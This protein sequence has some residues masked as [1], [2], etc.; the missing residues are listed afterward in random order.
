[1]R[2]LIVTRGIPGSG[3]STALRNMGLADFTLSPDAFNVILSGPVLMSDGTIQIDHS[4]IK[5]SWQAT[6][7]FLSA[8]MSK[9]ETVVVDATH[10]GDSDFAQYLELAQKHRYQV[11]CLDFSGTPLEKALHQNQLREEWRRVPEHVIHKMHERLQKNMVLPAW[12]RRIEVNTGTGSHIKE[13]DAFLS[14]ATDF[15]DRSR[16]VHVGDIH[17][18]VSAAK[19]LVSSLGGIRKDDQW[20]FVGDFVDRGIQNA[21]V[22]R[23][24]LSDVMPHENVTLLWGNH[25]DHI[26]REAVGLPPVSDEFKNATLPELM[27]AGI[28]RGDLEAIC[29]RL[30]DMV[31]Y[32][33]RDK[34]TM[35]THAGLSTIPA[36]PWMVSLHQLTHGTGAF[37]DNVDAQFERNTGPGYFQVHGHRNS[38]LLPI[39]ATERSFNLESS[40]E[41]GGHLSGLVLDET[42][43]TPAR[44][45]SRI[46]RPLRERSRPR[47]EYLTPPWIRNGAEGDIFL[48]EDILRDMRDHKD[49]RLSRSETMPH[50]SSVNF[51][52]KAF[53]KKNWDDLTV[54]A[55][56]LFINTDTREIVAR[57]Y[58]KFF[59]VGE[60]D[61]TSIASLRANMTFPA[62]VWLKENGFLGIVG[63]DRET[64]S[65]VVSSKSNLDGPFA[66]KARE[67]LEHNLKSDG[68]IDYLRRILRDYEASIAMEVIDPVWDPHIIEYD[69]P[70]VVLLDFVRR[71][72]EFESLNYDQLAKFGKSLDVRTKVKEFT[73][74]DWKAFEGWYAK[75]RKDTNKQIEGYVVEDAS[76]RQ[77]KVKTPFYL[78][79]KL[80]RHTKDAI[81]AHRE[82][83][84]PMKYGLMDPNFLETLGIGFMKDLGSSFID[85]C[86]AQDSED[87][88]GDIISMRK[89]FTMDMRMNRENN[90]QPIGP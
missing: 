18:C 26:H 46:F 65:L 31:I 20:I 44:V 49:I 12:L 38:G 90:P 33:W 77:V 89:R 87:L 4:N 86:H 24:L 28:T 59:T 71:S 10:T 73:L 67:I 68:R 25:E 66:K 2:K 54:R 23:W 35:V 60:N 21:E 72:I 52:R 85:W 70:H 13:L 34:T 74:P 5:E 22:V 8:R 81:V 41:N 56:G 42:G 50:I 47:P 1:M 64:D 76:G 43:W 39:M 57:S 69:H 11:A 53:Y 36:H 75:I 40:I 16:I 51:T 19:E 27:Q 15:S 30:E 29:A 55:R 17:G 58:D 14:V 79:W 32:R 88:R 45:R 62:T 61:E 63:Y 7:S 83:G 9:G 6:L 48:S 84:K 80:C 37:Q 3:K 82:N 78:F